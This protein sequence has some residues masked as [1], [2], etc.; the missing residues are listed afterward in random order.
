M[1]T[2]A[3]LKC[4]RFKDS[5]GDKTKPR[6]SKLYRYVDIHNNKKGQ[7]SNESEVG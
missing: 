6:V 4:Q 3:I 7:D 1:K 2:L 5:E